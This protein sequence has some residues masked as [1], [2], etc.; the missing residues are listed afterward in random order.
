ML[1]CRNDSDHS[2]VM[3]GRVVLLIIIMIRTVFLVTP[4]GPVPEVMYAQ[5]SILQLLLPE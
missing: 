4:E 2:I 3:L 1:T 5:E